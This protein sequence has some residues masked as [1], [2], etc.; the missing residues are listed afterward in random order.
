[1][2]YFGILE[3]YRN[4]R[5]TGER[6][7]AGRWMAGRWLVTS[8]SAIYRPSIGQR[9]AIHRP[10][11]FENYPESIIEISTSIRIRSKTLIREKL[12]LNHD[13]EYA[14][15]ITG[16]HIITMDGL[17]THCKNHV[18]G[19][20]YI[21]DALIDYM[22]WRKQINGTSGVSQIQNNCCSGLPKGRL[23]KLNIQISIINILI[24]IICNIYIFVESYYNV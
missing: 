14:N 17:W 11:F 7:A 20:K 21:T 12:A 18:N 24:T 15:P 1:M 4:D 19:N 10:F 8:W 2:T 9:P 16:L 22:T 6:P 23:W 5:L 13:V 3:E